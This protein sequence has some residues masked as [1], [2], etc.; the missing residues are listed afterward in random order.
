MNAIQIML[1]MIEVVV[2][3][4]GIRLYNIAEDICRKVDCIADDVDRV[5]VIAKDVFDKMEMLEPM[6]EDSDAVHD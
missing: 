5:L 3:V 6:K 1:I 4:W 2:I